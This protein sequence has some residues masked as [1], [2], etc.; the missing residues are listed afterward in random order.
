MVRKNCVEQRA[1]MGQDT[2]EAILVM[3]AKPGNCLDPARQ[4]SSATLKNLKSAYANSLK[5]QEVTRQEDEKKK[6]AESDC[7]TV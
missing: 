5:R 4:L 3:K 2:T 6:H 1:S 7:V